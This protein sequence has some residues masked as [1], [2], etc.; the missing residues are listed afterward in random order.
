[1]EEQ[2]CKGNNITHTWETTLPWP[3]KLWTT[4]DWYFHTN[5]EIINAH[6]DPRLPLLW[7]SSE[8]LTRLRVLSFVNK[9]N[10]SVGHR[11]PKASN[12][13]P[14]AHLASPQ[15]FWKPFKCTGH[16]WYL[17]NTSILT[18]CIPT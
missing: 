15:V 6:N 17:L 12:Q 8:S 7:Q 1:M 2:Q 16:V 13:L 5:L 4:L 11:R 10:E 14:F 18:W 3:L 9:R